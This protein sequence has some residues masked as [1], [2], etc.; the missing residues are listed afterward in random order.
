MKAK[1]YYVECEHGCCLCTSSSLEKV[2]REMLSEQ[3]TDHFITAHL[4]TQENIE[5]RRSNEL[6]D[7]S[8]ILRQG[9]PLDG[10]LC[11]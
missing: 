3:G 7:L 10:S 6:S 5:R 2:R 1:I 4:A 8:N 9:T 11:R